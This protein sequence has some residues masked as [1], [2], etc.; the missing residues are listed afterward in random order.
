MKT[1]TDEVICARWVIL[2]A[3]NILR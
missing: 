2:T 3:H 1:G